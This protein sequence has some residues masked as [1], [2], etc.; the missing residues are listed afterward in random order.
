MNR[1]PSGIE[2]T[3]CIR[4][5]TRWLTALF[6]Q[7]YILRRQV[8]ALLLTELNIQEQEWVAESWHEETEGT[9]PIH[10]HHFSHHNYSI[11][12]ATVE[13]RIESACY[14]PLN[15]SCLLSCW[16]LPLLIRI[17]YAYTLGSSL[18]FP[19]LH[20]QSFSVGTTRPFLISKAN[21]CYCPEMH[22]SSYLIFL[23]LKKH[24]RV[25]L[26]PVALQIDFLLIVL[27]GPFWAG[28]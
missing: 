20:F 23:S 28:L 21:H 24:D 13:D 19:P 2:D 10:N 6:A 14:L 26:L 7:C 15:A 3:G 8:W 9:W 12:G 17:D 16:R 25:C 11:Y 27:W 22:A 1:C 5:S 4:F 18:Y